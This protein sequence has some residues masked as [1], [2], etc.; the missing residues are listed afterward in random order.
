ME[1]KETTLK[2]KVGDIC[3]LM[4]NNKPTRVVIVSIKYE[5]SE[6][7]PIDANPTIKL[8]PEAQKIKTEKA[9]YTISELCKDDTYCRSRIDVNPSD[10]FES[11][12]A[13]VLSLLKE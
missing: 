7:I 10:L 4:K 9:Y 12:E 2:W 6:Y 1:I 5:Y 3:W 11:K 8:P 13:L